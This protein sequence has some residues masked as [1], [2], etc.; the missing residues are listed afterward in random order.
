MKLYLYPSKRDS[1]KNLAPSSICLNINLV[2]LPFQQIIVDILQHELLAHRSPIWTGRPS[3]VSRCANTGMRERK[4]S[5]S[6]RRGVARRMHK[7]ARCRPAAHAHSLWV[8]HG[9]ANNADPRATRPDG[10][11]HYNNKFADHFYPLC[12]NT[13]RTA[14]I[15]LH[16]VSWQAG[17]R[18]LQ[19]HRP[20]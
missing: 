15:C 10:Q 1:Q 14:P 2:R 4:R 18:R 3:P 12:V 11:T 8:N 7:L 17:R 19:S 13:R 9:H 5:I 16:F 20:L 6:V